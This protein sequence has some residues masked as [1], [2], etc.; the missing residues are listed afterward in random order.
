MT[1]DID[2]LAQQMREAANHT[3]VASHAYARSRKDQRL[4][5]EAL[6]ASSALRRLATTDNVLALLDDRDRLVA[7]AAAAK[8]TMEMAAT[9][10]AFWARRAE[11]AEAALSAKEQECEGLKVALADLV[12]WFPEKPSEPEWRL[13]AGAFGADD[14]LAAARAFATS[15]GGN[16]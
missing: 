16:G 13:R 5:G 4:F 10:G 15:G 6:A 7:E 1:T 8:A 14:A 3:I 2:K 12:S 11:N 9:S